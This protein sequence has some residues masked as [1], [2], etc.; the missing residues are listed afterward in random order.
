MNKYLVKLA[1]HLDKKGLHKEANYVD[2]ILRKR[3]DDA[4]IGLDDSAAE[5]L[6]RT[7]NDIMASEKITK[8][9]FLKEESR[10]S[11]E[12]EFTKFKEACNLVRLGQ[13]TTEEG[14]TVSCDE[15]GALTE[16]MKLAVSKN[17]G[18]KPVTYQFEVSAN[19]E[20]LEDYSVKH[21]L[22]FKR[23][24]DIVEDTKGSGF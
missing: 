11:S 9:N 17:F 16:K 15:E 19:Q 8:D 7:L 24:S 23:L 10:N 21:T 1:N 6:K 12:V 4:M 20:L 5:A 13:Y 18:D 22:S 3:A 2:W 14:V